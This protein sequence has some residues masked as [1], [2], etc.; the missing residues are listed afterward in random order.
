MTKY[1]LVGQAA[2]RSKVKVSH[3][4]FATEEETYEEAYARALER[5]GEIYRLAGKVTAD[6]HCPVD[7]WIKIYGESGIYGTKVKSMWRTRARAF[8]PKWR[9]IKE[10]PATAC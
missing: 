8:G 4:E 9:K 10:E 3:Y 6:G 2:I 7:C 5:S 1:V